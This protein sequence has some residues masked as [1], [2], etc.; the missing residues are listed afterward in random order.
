MRISDWSSDVCSSD[1]DAPYAGYVQ[2]GRR[3]DG[4]G[5]TNVTNGGQLR[6]SAGESVNTNT[7][8]PGLQIARDSGSLGRAT[9]DGNGSQIHMIQTVPANGDAE[10]GG[11]YVHIGRAG[12]G[13]LTVS[14]GG[15]LPGEAVGR[16]SWRER[17]GQVV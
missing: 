1:L 9:V 4:D 14:H 5:E 13:S 8:E 3:R 10:V 6:I 17:G 11:P 12:Q 16:A 2:V 15:P 7:Y